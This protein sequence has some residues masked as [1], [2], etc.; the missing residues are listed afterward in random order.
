MRKHLRTIAQHGI[1]TDVGK[2]PYIAILAH[3]SR[4]RDESERVYALLHRHACLI[5]LEQLGY[6]LIRIV[7]TYEGSMHRLLQ[8]HII[9]YKY[10]G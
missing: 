3:L 4:G 7:H 5:E 10:D 1:V 6:A 2:R 9:V 8:Y